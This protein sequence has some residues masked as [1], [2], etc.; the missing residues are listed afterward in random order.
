M[1]MKSM[2]QSFMMTVM[3]ICITWSFFKIK[4]RLYEL[5][6]PSLI[7]E[8]KS[9]MYNDAYDEQAKDIYKPSEKNKSIVTLT[10]T[11]V[12]RVLN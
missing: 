9:D 7:N 11:T 1:C 2:Y 3:L 4:Q 5:G 8:W 10:D 6:H 12:L